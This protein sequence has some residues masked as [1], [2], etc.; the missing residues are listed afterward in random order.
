MADS[1]HNTPERNNATFLMNAAVAG[2]S[3]DM[4][5]VRVLADMLA[6]TMKKIHGGEWRVQ[7][8]HDEFVT[9]VRRLDRAMPKPAKVRAI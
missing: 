6:N 1:A 4:L 5:S 2:A 7:I 3:S 8:E 9:V